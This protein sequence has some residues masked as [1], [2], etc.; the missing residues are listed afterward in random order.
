M[1]LGLV[2]LLDG[3]SVASVRGLRLISHVMRG[4]CMGVGG[5]CAC[6]WLLLCC[7]HFFFRFIFSLVV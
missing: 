7:G 6:A 1:E 5:F 3:T 4:V 2:P